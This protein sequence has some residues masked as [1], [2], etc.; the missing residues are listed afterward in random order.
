MIASVPM[1]TDPA[2]LLNRPGFWSTYY[3][4]RVVV[5]DD[6][7]D[8]AFLNRV[9][10]DDP[11][12]DHRALFGQHWTDVVNEDMDEE[13]QARAIAAMDRGAVL[14][15]PFA[16]GYT[17]SIQFHGSDDYSIGH[18]LTGPGGERRIALGH[19]DTHFQLPIL[20][21]VEAWRIAA[22]IGRHVVTGTFA[23]FPV[24]FTLPL[25][26]AVTWA[27]TRDEA[28]QARATLVQAWTATGMLNRSR[29]ITLTDRLVLCVPDLTWRSDPVQGWINDGIYSRR[30]P[31]NRHWS[32]ADFT[33]FRQF[34]GTLAPT[35]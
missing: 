21:W 2:A 35:G 28:A 16:S 27:T 24:E 25:L 1:V 14:N 6:P 30:N 31:A 33:A 18:L 3:G 9:F 26:A 15:L 11:D 12:L 4:W 17:W 20:R 34:L 29:A 13:E 8:E 10:G 5:D 22:H 19:D 32:P 23:P 7:H